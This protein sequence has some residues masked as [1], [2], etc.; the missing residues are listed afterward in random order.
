MEQHVLKSLILSS[1]V[2]FTQIAVAEPVVSSATCADPD[3]LYLFGNS[4]TYNDSAKNTSL[5]LETISARGT[6]KV[7]LHQQV[8]QCSLHKDERKLIESFAN[9]K[10]LEINW[11]YVENEW[12]LLPALVSQEGDLIAAKGNFINGGMGDNVRFTSPWTESRLQ[13]VE[14]R[15]NSGLKKK[16]DLRY[17]SVAI[18]RS[19]PA[20]NQ[21]QTLAGISSGMSLVEI[22]PTVTNEEI[23]Q[24]VASGQYDV[25][26]ADSLFLDD[27]IPG[28]SKLGVAFDL[29]EDQSMSWVVR[30]KSPRLLTELNQFLDKH[31]LSLQTVSTSFDDLPEIKQRRTLRMI[32]YRSPLN[33]YLDKGK[34]RGFE[35]DLLH[36]YAEKNK[37]RLDVVL[38]NSHTEMQQMLL[39]GKGDIIAAG[40][41]Q[42]LSFKEGVHPTSAY[43]H[44]SPVIIGRSGEAAMIDVRDLLGRTITLAKESPYLEYFQNLQKQGIDF[45]ISLTKEDINTEATLFMVSMGMY[46]LTV[47]SSHQVKNEL[48]RHLGLQAHF[49]LSE[50]EPLVWVVR[51][52]NQRLLAD[53]NDYLQKEYRSS[54]YNV[55]QNRYIKN[56]FRTK[57]SSRLLSLRVEPELSPY[58]DLTKHYAEEY[59][60]DWRLIT[61]IMYQESQFDPKAYSN[62]GAEGLMQLIPTTAEQVGVANSY[63]PESNIKGGVRYLSYLRG[64]F[65]EDLLLE[66]KTW[67]TLA[68]Y[69]AGF[70]R[71]KAARKL[72]VEMGLD[73]NHWFGNVEKAMLKLAKPY[74]KDGEKKRIC[75]CGQTVVYV[76]EI[77]VRYNNYRRFHEASEVA[78]QNFNDFESRW[79]N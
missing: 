31:H 59:D 61:A 12:E 55:V 39:E 47:L 69:N 22:P 49:A 18:K 6:L 79:L 67:F 41:P 77:K 29:T 62:A 32:T 78:I 7:L 38:A 72:A 71:V 4:K 25:T 65:E 21:M 28:D 54:F 40:V 34:L 3:K 9:N 33:Y 16:N 58:D 74:Y 23:M 8:G 10:G 70:Y 19:S 75:R 42:R 66:D 14:R 45:A 36:K 56:P 15:D 24:R 46:D 35:Y 68:A 43:H 11:V 5:D 76:R 27:Y 17:R 73:P 37:L 2:L 44:A 30:N 26:I 20:W 13:V 1:L 53:V 60:F 48:S 64:K 50:P 57:A 52:D 63:H 51:N